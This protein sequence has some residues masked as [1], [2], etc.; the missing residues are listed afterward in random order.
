MVKRVNFFPK[1]KERPKPVHAAPAYSTP[2]H[3]EEEE[4]EEL[5]DWEKEV[6]RPEKKPEPEPVKPKREPKPED[7]AG[8]DTFGDF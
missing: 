5:E 1:N 4:E 7:Y 2:G 3:E 8:I 6:V